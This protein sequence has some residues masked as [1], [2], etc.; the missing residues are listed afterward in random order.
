MRRLFAFVGIVAVVLFARFCIVILDE[1]EQA[2]RT[3]LN[4]P[5]PRLMGYSLNRPLLT[6]PGLYLRIPGLHQIHRFDRRRLR[7]DSEP[8]ALYTKGKLPIEVDYYAIWRIDDPRRFFEGVREHSEALRRLDTV[9]YS[10]LRKT[11]ALYTLEDLLSERRP[12]IMGQVARQCDEKLAPLGIRV[13]DLRIRRSDYPEGNLAQIFARMRTERERFAKKARAEG[14]EAA[15]EIRSRAERESRVILAE[16]TRKA[17]KTR[18]T[19]DARAA[20]IFAGAYGQDPE[21]YAFIKSLET[22]R[23]TLAEETMLILT[24]RSYF[25]R[26]LFPN[27]G[28]AIRGSPGS[29][30]AP[31][32]GT[33]P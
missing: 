16:A 14:D 4:D 2:F 20:A 31:A 15:R 25:L 29:V 24:P 17:A 30:G 21:F 8:R 32:P 9:T 28:K 18:G 5:E 11:L 1:R 22:Y 23:A 33:A 3:L 13:L 27:H 10:E 7:Y 6:E 19:G 26:Y 12:V